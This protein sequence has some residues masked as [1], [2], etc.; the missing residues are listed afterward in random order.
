MIFSCHLNLLWNNVEFQY[1]RDERKSPEN[2]LAD[3]ARG[4]SKDQVHPEMV[5]DLFGLI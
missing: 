1:F 4:M 2:I 5:L 3:D